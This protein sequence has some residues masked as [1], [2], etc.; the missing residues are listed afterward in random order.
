MVRLTIDVDQAGAM[1]Y[2]ALRSPEEI[3]EA[4][5]QADVLDDLV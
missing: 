5:T 4:D 2:K 1:A 3:I